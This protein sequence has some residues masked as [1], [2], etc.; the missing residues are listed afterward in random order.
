[1]PAEDTPGAENLEIT[2][3]TE[4]TLTLDWDP[5]TLPPEVDSI[6]QYRVYRA[7]EPG[8]TRADYTEIATTMTPGFDDSGLESGVRYHYRIGADL[9]VP[10]A[11]YQ[12][13]ITGFREA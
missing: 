11:D 1:M 9:F 3:E 8:E 6:E 5:P 12:V 4:T 2:K 13:T 7:T 10:E